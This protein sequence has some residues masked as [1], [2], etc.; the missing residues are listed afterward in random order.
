MH[1]ETDTFKRKKRKKKNVLKVKDSRLTN[2]VETKA[3]ANSS[4]SK[5]SSSSS[6]ML[7]SSVR[8][9]RTVSVY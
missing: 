4:S 6:N 1:I 8:I 2:N 9:K 3:I 5:N 7:L